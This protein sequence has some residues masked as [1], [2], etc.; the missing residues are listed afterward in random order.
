MPRIKEII[1]AVQTI[2]TPIIT[3]RLMVEDNESYAR[4]VKARIEQT[5]LSEISLWFEEVVDTDNV[6]IAI[7]LDMKRISVLQL[8][9]SAYSIRDAIF[10]S[11]MKAKIA[12]RLT[13]IFTYYP[14]I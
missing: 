7:R 13:L 11:K 10:A 4:R 6:Y 2:S 5:I 14:D 3:A 12:V 8:E 9:V 1:N